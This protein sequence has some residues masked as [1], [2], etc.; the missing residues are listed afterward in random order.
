MK[1]RYEQIVSVATLGTEE[2]G[3]RT[4]TPFICSSG[5]MSTASCPEPRNEQT[6]HRLA[7]TVNK[8]CIG[9][10]INLCIKKNWRKWR[11]PR[12]YSP[13]PTSRTLESCGTLHTTYNTN[14]HCPVISAKGFPPHSHPYPRCERHPAQSQEDDRSDQKSESITLCLGHDRSEARTSVCPLD[15]KFSDR[16]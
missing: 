4:L 6:M 2:G 12:D 5:G 8:T 15:S 1:K 16:E 9:V 14:Q 13:P 3:M 10:D 7:V 11:K